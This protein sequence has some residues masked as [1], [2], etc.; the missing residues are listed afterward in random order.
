MGW[1]VMLNPVPV[2][3]VPVMITFLPPELLIVSVFV[4]ELPIETVPNPRGD[5]DKKRE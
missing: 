5:G 2:T 4:S 3:E 1:C